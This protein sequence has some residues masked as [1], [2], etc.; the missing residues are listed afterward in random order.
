MKSQRTTEGAKRVA[1]ANGLKYVTDTAPGITRRGRN[2]RFEYYSPGN[3]RLRRARVLTRINQLAIPPA[4]RDVWI[5]SDPRGHLQATGRDARGRKQYR[6]H[7]RWH[8]LRD[9]IKF[10]RMIEFG[11]ALPRL[12]RRL[13]HDLALKALPLEKVLAL[14]VTL[15][16]VTRLRIGNP[17]Y[18][19]DNQS[20]GLST[21]R[22]R[23]VRFIRDG[24]ALLRFRGKGG[25]MHEV[26]I[27]DRRLVR[28]VRKC[29]ELP[30]QHLFQYRDDDGAVRDIDSGQIN[31]Y[32]RAAMGTDFTAKDF[33]T[34]SATVRAIAILAAAPLPEP[35]SDAACRQLVVAAVRQVAAEL[36]NTP[37][38]CRKSYINPVVFEAWRGG[39]LPQAARANGGLSPQQAEKIALAFL[40][41]EARRAAR[42]P[43]K[44]STAGSV[45]RADLRHFW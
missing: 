44:R 4:Y 41:R 9:A 27:D 16:D 40:K 10:D 23:H 36:R 17:E 21:L 37:A 3:H 24:R 19:R 8:A 2:G 22:N 38:V 35:V 18:A 13:R 25:A 26:V 20:F 32:L 34:W 31:D 6:Y 39:R 14:I 12:R 1:V 15:L 7:Q 11:S 30:G 29:Q 43:S 5:C 28:L 45:A 33:R 42:A